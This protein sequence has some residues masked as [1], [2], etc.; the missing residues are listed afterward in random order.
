MKK[1]LITGCSGYIGS[2]LCKELENDYD[3]WGLDIRPSLYPIKEGQFIQHDINHPFGEFPEEF[4]A[5]VHLAARVRVNES[6]QM[7]I[8]YYITNLNGT[9]NV[10]EKIKTK[11]FIF[12][13]TGVAE[14]CYD[15]YG[16]SKKAAEDC[17]IEYC[18]ERSIKPF[19]IFRFYN[20]IGSS[21]F[22][23][24]NP[25]SLMHNLLQAPERGDFTIFGNDYDTPD[26]TCLR[27]YIHVDEICEGIKLAI[28][29]PADKIEQLGHG[30]G[31][32]VKEMV[33]LFKQVNNVD[34]QVN[35]SERRSGDLPKTVLKEKSRYMKELYTLEELLKV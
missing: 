24:T 12:S 26:G 10:L 17:V 22:A 8:N 1:V 3:I 4:D 7:P 28:E 18:T 14:Y 13:S 16:I 30:V 29:E 20:V 23:P 35:Y 19:T 31:R 2:H 34:F 27:D 9:T 25:D 21:G 5:V 33:E 11:N 32:S 6:R 15:P